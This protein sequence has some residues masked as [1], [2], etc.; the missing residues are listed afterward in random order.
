MGQ[1]FRRA[2]RL[3]GLLAVLVAAAPLFAVGRQTVVGARVGKNDFAHLESCAKEL[4]AKGCAA[5]V[6]DLLDVMTRLGDDGAALAKTRDA[7][8]KSLEKDKGK[9]KPPASGAAV[10]SIA[11]TL[12]SCASDMTK[13]LAAL[14]AKDAATLAEQILR[15]DDEQPLAHETLGQTFEKPADA[16]AKAKSDAKAGAWLTPEQKRVLARRRE[17]Q[18][19][20]VQARRLEIP[21]EVAPSTFAPLQAIDP[22]P[23]TVVRYGN[24]EF[25]SN[26]QP[27]RLQ[28]IVRRGLQ[29][30][31][32]SKFVRGLPLEVPAALKKLGRKYVLLTAKTQY[33]KAIDVA[34]AAKGIKEADAAAARERGGYIDERGFYVSEGVSEVQDYCF[35]VLVL[36]LRYYE[37]DDPEPQPCLVKGHLEWLC[38]TMFGSSL[39]GIVSESKEVPHADAT[40][41]DRARDQREEKRA[42]EVR[43]AGISGARRWMTFLASRGQDP[44]WSNSF[45]SDIALLIDLDLVKSTFV[46]EYL[47]ENLAFNDLLRTTGTKSG[48][49]RTRTEQI[50]SKLDGGLPAFEARFRAWLLPRPVPVVQR[51]ARPPASEETPTKEEEAALVA[52][53]RVRKVAWD[54]AKYGAFEPMQVDRELSTACA[55]HVRYLKLHPDQLA[56]WPDAHEE[57]P[58]QEGFSTEGCW[59]GTHAVIAPGVAT[60]EEAV[61]GW[62]GTFYHRLPL[63]EPGLKRIGFDLADRIAVL[64]ASSLVVQDE[65]IGCMVWPARDMHDVPTRFVA[66]GELPHPVPGV[67]ERAFGYPITLQTTHQNGEFEL[68]LFKGPKRDGPAVACHV[69]TPA[70]PSNPDLAP[71]GAFCLLPKARLEPRTTYT[72]V[73]TPADGGAPLV[74]SFTTGE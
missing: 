5:E 28:R 46:V 34:V 57:Y 63:L 44:P 65:L 37:G 58:E 4:A 39:P 45:V 12:H 54:I 51:L 43:D 25:H 47:Q 36:G 6:A 50:E 53:D 62:M 67:D 68:V 55:L 21:L 41:S 29:A 59:A 8:A 40:T 24:L 18:T 52:L 1:P 30:M 27:E 10:A 56:K 2:Q 38:L 71:P 33:D 11:R 31:A 3:A 70:H 74:W 15:V 26:M 42:R 14:D 19:A 16:G 32:L 20:V 7:C 22:S 48:D 64:D 69:S 60:A 66:G 13:Q 9:A 49:K 72:V 73:A 35:V 17:I 61:A 23:A